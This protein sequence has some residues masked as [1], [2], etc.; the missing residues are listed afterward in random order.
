MGVKTLFFTLKIEIGIGQSEILKPRDTV[1]VVLL[2]HYRPRDKG[3]VEQYTVAM[4]WL[5][6]KAFPK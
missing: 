5:H 4:C 1:C 3:L 2:V 6:L